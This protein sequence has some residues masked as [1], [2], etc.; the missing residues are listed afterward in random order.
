MN[1][2]QAL[3][4][5]HRIDREYRCLEKAAAVLQWDQETCL[6]AGGV[7]ERA[8]QLALL[9][10][11]AHERLIDPETGRLLAELGSVPENPRGDRALPEPER[12]FLRVTRRRYE[13][14]VKLPADFVSAAA[15]AGGLSQAAWAGARRANDFASFLPHLETMIDFARKKAAYWGFGNGA[16]SL[17]DGLL[18]IYEP[19]MSASETGGLFAALRERLVP[20]LEKIS[21]CPP[22]DTSFLKQDFPV[23]QQAA[24]SQRLMDYLGF[25]RGRGRLDTSAHPFTTSLGSDDIRITTRYF[26]DNILSGLFSVI[27][28]S[29]HAFY[30]MG[31]PPE[32]RG[33]CLADGASMAVH[34]SQSR[35]LENVIGRSRSFWTGCFPLL[36]EYFPRQLKSAGAE[37]F[38]RAV[39]EVKPSP[40]RVD[41]DEISYSLHII[42]RFELE[43]R[44][45]G[46]ELAPEKLP[47]VW[48]DYT[49]EYLGLESETVADGVL[50]DIHWSMGSFGYFPSYALGNLYGLQIL[51]KL[52]Q[53]IP[54]YE[55][56]V[57]EGKFSLLYDWL[58][59][60]IYRWGCRL[61]PGELLSKITGEKLSVNPFLEYIEG[62]YSELYG[63]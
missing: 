43:K 55:S 61:E 47:P 25:D 40:V 7:E 23:E 13:R 49:R 38:Y 19:G 33:S 51:K 37:N 24:F 32:L 50:Q 42:F 6:P 34:E 17:Y 14:A 9:E 22:P 36:R 57:A 2:G 28:E 41:A 45:I 62:K 10:G 58:G 5:L 35:F 4:T 15:R 1:S 30:E 11:I 44:L 56:A 46:G 8:E 29:G 54:A 60:N 20:L 63:F 39:N 21:L 27:H 31:F 18:D 48:N 16:G 26:P 12:D 3:E 53:D 59:E 52:K